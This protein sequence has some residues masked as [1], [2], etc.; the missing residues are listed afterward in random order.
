VIRVWCRD[1]LVLDIPAATRV[2]LD[3]EAGVLY[4]HASDEVEPMARFVIANVIGW[5]DEATE[6]AEV[7]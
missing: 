5:T 2:E 4:V 1:R 3:D 7:R 6:V